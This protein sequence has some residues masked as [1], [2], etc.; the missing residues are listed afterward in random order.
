MLSL[1]VYQPDSIPSPLFPPTMIPEAKKSHT[2]ATVIPAE[3]GEEA[4]LEKLGYKQG[5]CF[6]DLI[7]LVTF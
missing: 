7:T 6:A 2:V 5:I 4:D 1:D 3:V